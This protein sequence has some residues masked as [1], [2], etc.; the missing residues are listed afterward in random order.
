M[1]GGEPLRA[2][3]GRRREDAGRTW[4]GRV[5]ASGWSGSAQVATWRR[6]IGL[7]DVA[8]V[9]GGGGGESGGDKWRARVA[10]PDP[11]KERDLLWLGGRGRGGLAKFGMG[12][13]YMEGSR[14]RGVSE[15][16]DRNR[17]VPVGG[18]V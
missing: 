5:A 10:A 1:R 7:G 14:V 6:G 2:S 4:G 17:T 16:S 3:A 15:P 9:F 11:R 13:I 12:C 18:G 8:A